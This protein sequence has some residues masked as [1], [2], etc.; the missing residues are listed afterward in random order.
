MNRHTL[1]FALST[2]LVPSAA[3]A[4]SK[5]GGG[6]ADPK[7]DKKVVAL[8]KE[9]AK[10]PWRAEGFESGCKELFG[11]LGSE[12]VKE[13]KADATLVNL[14]G[15][16]RVETRWL[17]A[18][19]LANHGAKAFADK[20]LAARVILA[21]KEEVGPAVAEPLG[22]AVGKI[23]AAAGLVDAQQALARD[24]KEPAMRIAIVGELLWTSKEHYAFVVDLAKNEKD[25]K[26]RARALSSFWTGTPSDKKPEVCAIW[27]DAASSS[28]DGISGDS[29]YHLSFWSGSACKDQY[30]GLLDVIDKRAGAGGVK[31][32]SMSSALG[33]LFD[34]AGATADHKKKALTVAAKLA[35]SRGNDGFARKMALD[36]L[37]KRDT[38]A[39]LALAKELADDPDSSVKGRA[40][41]L[42]DGK[43]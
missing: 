16:D 19:V 29:A 7:N 26:V 10:C 12:L 37:A 34:Q 43:P 15:D 5:V 28:D 24:H 6:L 36:A 31:R 22:R 17:A 21:A 1:A 33:Y 42:V 9:A 13:G 11:L 20:A 18:T 39:G 35:R 8:V 4:S 41:E 27:L 38:A 2:L 30:D 32:F 3:L 23:G 25:L 14:L 40:K